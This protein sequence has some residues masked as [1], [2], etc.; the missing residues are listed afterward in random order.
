MAQK[1]SKCKCHPADFDDEDGSGSHLHSW[2]NIY[3]RNEQESHP[4]VDKNDQ[5]FEEISM[6]SVG[7]G[8]DEVGDAQEHTP[9]VKKAAQ[10]PKRKKLCSSYCKR[11]GP[12]EQRK[13]ILEC[14]RIEVNEVESGQ[15]TLFK[16]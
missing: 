11:I 6:G 1:G 15:V 2:N 3:T 4:P 14:L 5:D 12:K 16:G 7:A 13:I 9:V 10:K 8:S